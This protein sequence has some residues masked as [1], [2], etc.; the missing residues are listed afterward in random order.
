MF[1]LE[2]IG[3]ERRVKERMEMC[4]RDRYITMMKTTLKLISRPITKQPLLRHLK[5]M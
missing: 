5:V 1:L 3:K 4:I 2:R